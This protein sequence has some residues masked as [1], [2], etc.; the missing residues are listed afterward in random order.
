M[1]ETVRE[2]R[3]LDNL[4][5]VHFIVNRLASE[6][7]RSVERED[8]VGTGVIGLIK[9]VDRFDAGRGVKFETYAS[10]LI[11]G[12]I[13]E[14]LRERDTASRSLRRKGRDIART[15]AE[16][17]VMLGRPPEAAEIAEALG[18]SLQDHQTTLRLLENA[19]EVSLEESVENDPQVEGRSLTTPEGLSAQ[20]SDP[21]VAFERQ[22]LMDIVTQGLEGLPE[23]EQAVVALYYGEDLTLKEIGMLFGVTESRICQLHEQALRRLKSSLAQDLDR[24]A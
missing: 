18:I 15:R 13:M 11:R 6:L 2:Q 10:C 3:I 5:L 17:S 9:A 22:N 19:N 7:P 14:S 4:E 20:L 21:A 12:E 23:R 1:T 24:A 8:L 16:L